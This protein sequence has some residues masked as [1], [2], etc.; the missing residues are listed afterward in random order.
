[1]FSGIGGQYYMEILTGQLEEGP[2]LALCYTKKLGM[3]FPLV[4]KNIKKLFQK[5]IDIYKS[6]EKMLMILHY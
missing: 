6:R 3:V 5:N 1:M 4:F 2:G